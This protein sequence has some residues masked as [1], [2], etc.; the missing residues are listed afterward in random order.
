MRKAIFKGTDKNK[1]S[2]NEQSD[3]R[4][5]GRHRPAAHAFQIGSLR[6][7]SSGVSGAPGSFPQAAK[8]GTVQKARAEAPHFLELPGSEC[9]AR[10]YQVWRCVLIRSSLGFPCCAGEPKNPVT[11]IRRM[12]ENE[13]RADPGSRSS[14]KSP[15]SRGFAA[16]LIYYGYRYHDPVTGR[17]PSRDPIGEAG[18][19]NLYGFVNNDGVNQIDVLGHQ[20]LP[21]PPTTSPPPNSTPDPWYSNPPKLDLSHNIREYNCGG[22]ACRTYSNMSDDEVLDFLERGFETDCDHDYC[23]CGEVKCRFYRFTVRRV[24]IDH[25]TGITTYSA[26]SIDWHV[27]CGSGNSVPEKYGDGNVS[28][29]NPEHFGA[30]TYVW[31]YSMEGGWFSRG[32]TFWNEIISVTEKKCYCLDK[33]FF[34]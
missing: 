6:A 11:M 32:K 16:V 25:T 23:F 14:R 5:R 20:T 13:F 21:A 22:L 28:H 15:E 26:P 27:N 3:W 2:P 29:G 33:D 9:V 30:G 24:T 1:A 8:Y 34:N 17:W 18:G 12:S 7:N 19:I 4:A 10:V 31:I